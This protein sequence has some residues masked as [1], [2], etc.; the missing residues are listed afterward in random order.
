MADFSGELKPASPGGPEILAQERS[1]SNINVDQL[2]QHLLFRD[3]FLARQK[4]VIAEMEKYPV[5]SK[6]TQLNLAR[7]DR[8]HLGLARAK[9]TR[10]LMV[11]HNW[12]MADWQMADY[13]ADEMGPYALTATMFVTSIKE[14]C[15]EEQH[16]RDCSY[17][18][19]PS[20]LICA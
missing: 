19:L 3:D 1:R 15:N 12:D 8:Y 20:P 16:C 5:Y 10:R 6:K 18:K 17:A 14:Q 4:K 11:K 9:T 7:P 13:L 2:A